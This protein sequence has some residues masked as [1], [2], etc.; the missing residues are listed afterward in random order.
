MRR[1]LIMC[2]VATGTLYAQDADEMLLM[3]RTGP[4]ETAFDL[5]VASATAKMYAHLQT[6]GLISEEEA[7]ETAAIAAD[8]LRRICGRTAALRGLAA[9][10][11]LRLLTGASIGTGSPEADGAALKAFESGVSRLEELGEELCSLTIE[12]AG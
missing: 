1:F 4:V 9:S 11:R 8:G 3:M 10:V 7:V 2:A 6:S 5:G 12:E